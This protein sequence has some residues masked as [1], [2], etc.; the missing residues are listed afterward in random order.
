MSAPQT[1]STYTQPHQFEPLL[2]QGGLDELALRTRQ[3]VEASHQLQGSAHPAT[4][5][6][7]QELVRSMNSYYSNRIEGQG[8]HPLN[9]DRALHQSFSD[10]P[11]VARR[12]RLALAHI[13]AERELETLCSGEGQALGSAFLVRAHHSLYSR[14][15]PEDR[16]TEEGHAIEPGV[17][18]SADV[19]VYRHQPP[20]SD[21]VPRFLAR[22]DAVYAR[23]WGLDRLL[24]AIACAHHRLVWVHPFL[25]G[26]GRASR[27]QVHCALH[28]LTGGLWSVNRG[29]ARKR[30]EYYRCLSAADMPRQGGLDGRGNLSERML[31][32]WCEFFIATCEDQAAFMAGMLDLAEM[33]KR[34]AALMLVRS[35]TDQRGDYRPEAVLPLHHVWA[36]GPVGRGEFVQMTGL[37][38]RTGRKLLSR[39]LADG[40]LVSDSPKG[41]VRIGLP[42]DALHILLPNLYPEAAMKEQ[43]L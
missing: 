5:Q 41:E 33:K 38:E 24:V 28:R 30:D 25:D 12:Q 36:A 29:L 11:D 10:Q 4:R 7:L 16:M 42:L 27:L 14:L 35:Q 34:L 8:T 9:I 22:A 39:L 15:G 37:G 40:V 20:T 31:L 6:A 32:Q 3:V 19:T 2:P 1:V 13:Q 23:P 17:T 26:N 21:S 18:R 43:H